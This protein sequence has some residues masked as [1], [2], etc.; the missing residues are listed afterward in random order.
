LSERSTHQSIF[1][2]PTWRC[3][4]NHCSSSVGRYANRK[5]GKTD[6][7]DAE[8]VARRFDYFRTET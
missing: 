3:W 5:R 8:A 4:W 6:A 1:L 2:P 7:A